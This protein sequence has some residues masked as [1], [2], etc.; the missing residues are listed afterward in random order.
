MSE[1][2]QND[3]SMDTEQAMSEVSNEADSIAESGKLRL[4]LTL[5]DERAG[6]HVLRCLAS[7]DGDISVTAH[8]V[9]ESIGRCHLTIDSVTE[10]QWEASKL[11]VECGYYDYPRE[12]NLEQLS[13]E[14]EISTSATSQRLSSVERKLMHAL[15]EECKSVRE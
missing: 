14:L 12:T 2:R 11:A 4:T 8:G 15:V 1:T 10:K 9:G 7:R 13:D 5:P 3:R 6:Q